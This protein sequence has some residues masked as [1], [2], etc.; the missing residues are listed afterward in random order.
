MKM[1]ALDFDDKAMVAVLAGTIA[2]V[3][4]IQ[5]FNPAKAESVEPARMYRIASVKEPVQQPYYTVTYTFAPLSEECRG[6]VI[7]SRH[8]QAQLDREPISE[9]VQLKAPAIQYAAR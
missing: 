9:V 3:G 5:W 7:P 1:S 4:A 6:Q 2:L 8:C